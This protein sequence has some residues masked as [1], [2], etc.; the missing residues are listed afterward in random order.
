MVRARPLFVLLLLPLS[1][2]F[3]SAA[4]QVKERSM[5]AP[6]PAPEVPGITTEDPFP[7]GC[8][9]C[10]VKYTTPDMDTRIS[11]YMSMWHDG[12]EPA[13][14]A[15]AQASAPSGV[16]LEGKHPDVGDALENIPAGCAMCHSKKSVA[17]PPLSNMIHRIHL[18][19]GGE[20]FYMTVFQGACTGC[21]KLD[22]S[23]GRWSMP[24]GPEE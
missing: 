2:L 20:N 3:L 21:H 6:Q 9:D 16:I 4:A 12:V 19:G 15:K 22:A 11:T 7:R 1:L 5:P 23:T 14:L 13:L 24:S 10:H 18:T 8:V 17:A